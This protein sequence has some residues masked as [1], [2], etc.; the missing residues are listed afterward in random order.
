MMMLSNVSPSAA[1]NGSTANNADGSSTVPSSSSSFNALLNEYTAL[2]TPKPTYTLTHYD[3]YF[4]GGFRNQHMRFVA[5]VQA[6][7]QRNISQLLLPSIRWGDATTKKGQSV[8]HEVLFDVPYWNKRAGEFGLPTLV[9]YEKNVLEK[10]QR[11]SSSTTGNNNN[12]E[13]EVIACFNVTSSM[14]SGLNE[15]KWRSSGI[16]LR[17]Y[18]IWDYLGQPSQFAHC[19]YTLDSIHSPSNNTTSNNED[20]GPMTYLVPHGGTKM[21]GRLWWEY[22]AMQSHRNKPNENGTYP[23]HLP[24][25]QA[26]Y[27]LLIPSLPIRRAIRESLDEA[28]STAIDGGTTTTSLNKRTVVALHPRIEHDMLLHE[29]CNKYMP[30][31]LTKI[32]ESIHTMPKFDLLF[33]A[34]SK[35]LVDGKPP[36]EMERDP[37]LIRLADENRVM[38]ENA[39]KYGVFGTK[40]RVRVDLDDYCEGGA[41]A[42]TGGGGGSSVGSGSVGGGSVGSSVVRDML[43]NLASLWVND[44]GVIGGLETSRRW[45]G[46]KIYMT[47][48]QIE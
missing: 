18:S 25:E 8:G 19:K 10:R 24:L 6:A 45:K 13:E 16:I 26:I 22:D 21:A 31:N 23:H 29:M 2:T 20:N 38:L 17:K 36:L 47:I 3:P 11:R 9:R 33:M 4:I 39:R 44:S 12:E 35:A 14:Y 27:K 34:V 32:F 7:V 40:E 37:E 15:K 1:A 42:N 30:M 48:N 41:A 28:T 43:V 46:K 5:F